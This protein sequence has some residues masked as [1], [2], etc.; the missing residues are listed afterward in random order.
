MKEIAQRPGRIT[1][2]A[3]G[4]PVGWSISIEYG[5]GKS[6][7]TALRA[8]HDGRRWSLVSNP[9]SAPD[10]PTYTLRRFA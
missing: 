2:K 10:T 5:E 6:L 4:V 9:A 3:K 8:L 1:D 7:V